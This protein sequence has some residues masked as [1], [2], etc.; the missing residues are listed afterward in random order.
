[1]NSPALQYLCTSSKVHPALVLRRYRVRQLCLAGSGLRPRRSGG[2][3]QR[4]LSLF[5]RGRTQGPKYRAPSP[6]PRCLYV[7]GYRL[8][9]QTNGTFSPNP[10]LFDPVEH[11]I[12]SPKCHPAAAGFRSTA[13]LQL[14]VGKSFREDRVHAELT[15]LIYLQPKSSEPRHVPKTVEVLGWY[16]HWR[17]SCRVLRILGLP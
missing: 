5:H 4:G 15:G 2:L 9:I 10:R 12:V 8:F 1:M 14:V 13:E 11:W 6:L 3:A 16:Q 7:A 17:L